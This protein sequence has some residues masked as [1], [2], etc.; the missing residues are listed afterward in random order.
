MAGP[1]LL[2]SG[3]LWLALRSA[4]AMGLGILNSSRTLLLTIVVVTPAAAVRWPD[5]GRRIAR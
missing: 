4:P 5:R 1:V 3:N 2:F